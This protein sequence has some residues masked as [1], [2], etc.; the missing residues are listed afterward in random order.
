M[1]AA[2]GFGSNETDSGI[3]IAAYGFGS[4][5]VVVSVA[6]VIRICAFVTHQISA[7]LAVERNGQVVSDVAPAVDSM[8]NLEVV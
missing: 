5:G 3:G 6:K 8:V 4:T 7:S 1:I 2:Y